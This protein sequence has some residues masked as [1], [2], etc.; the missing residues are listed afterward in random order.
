MQREQAPRSPSDTKRK[1]LTESVFRIR[2]SSLLQHSGTSLQPSRATPVIAYVP[3]GITQTNNRLCSIVVGVSDQLSYSVTMTL[4]DGATAAKVDGCTA[5]RDVAD[6][7][8][9]NIKA[10]A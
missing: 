4:G 7:V 10:R 2:L 6:T 8:M 9:T 5:A 3:K 1:T